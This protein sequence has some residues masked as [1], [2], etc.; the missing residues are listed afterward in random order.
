MFWDCVH[1]VPDVIITAVFGFIFLETFEEN[2][3][4]ANKLVTPTIENYT[5]N[6]N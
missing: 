5:H 2:S 3:I 4:S 6:K 1:F